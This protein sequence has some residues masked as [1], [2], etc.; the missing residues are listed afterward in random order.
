MSQSA[1]DQLRATHGVVPVS[2]E[3]EGHSWNKIS[4]GVYGF[5]YAPGNSDGGLF[6]KQP[7]QSFEMHKLADGALLIIGF[8]TADQAAKIKSNAAQ[9]IALYPE[10]RE[11][12]QQL[13]ALPHARI[14]S[15]KA[16]DRDDFNCLRVSLRP[17]V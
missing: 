14:A 5:T 10:P 6:L 8:T 12:F 7:R 9:D 4:N 2:Q 11:E 17:S 16:L 13:A 1:I 15:A 3:D